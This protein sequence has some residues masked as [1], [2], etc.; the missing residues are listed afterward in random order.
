MVVRQFS[1]LSAGVRFPVPAQNYKV[2]LS[3]EA[4]AKQGYD[5]MN[6]DKLEFPPKPQETYQSVL[7]TYIPMLLEL[8]NDSSLSLEVKEKLEKD[9]QDRA[10]ELKRNDF[11]SPGDWWY[12]TSHI[13][14]AVY[15][16][17]KLGD[18]DKKKIE[19]TDLRSA[20]KTCW[21]ELK[22]AHRS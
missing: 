14:A 17:E 16:P 20:I 9:I 3:C 5:T 8:V 13:V 12:N 11:Y 21:D 6:K 22:E 7:D 1:K 19:F 18:E 15:Q 2:I 10:T 4:L